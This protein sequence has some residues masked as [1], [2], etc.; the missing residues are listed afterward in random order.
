MA[1]LVATLMTARMTAL[2]VLVRRLPFAAT[3][4]TAT[5]TAT[6]TAATLF[7]VYG[8]SICLHGCAL[9]GEIIRRILLIVLRS[10]IGAGLVRRRMRVGVLRSIARIQLLR[11]TIPLTG[12]TTT[13]ASATATT[14]TAALP[15]ALAFGKV[16]T[17]AF[18]SY[19]ALVTFVM[20][21][22]VVY[23][24]VRMR[25]IACELIVLQ[26]GRR[27]RIF[28]AVI[29]EDDDAP[30]GFNAAD[31]NHA[32]R[33]GK[34]GGV[35]ILLLARSTLRL[36]SGLIAA[37]VVSA[38]PASTNPTTPATMTTFVAASTLTA[39]ATSTRT[40]T[41]AAATPP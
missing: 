9:S 41:T 15:F 30:F 1:L 28:I 21:I 20:P 12:T 27:R 8:N 4:P 22:G 26:R 17:L 35:S 37:I 40:A 24:I 3:T 18:V 11:S 38:A 34:P 31:I 5:A 6:T 36:V 23:P 32:R 39:L 25:C 2:I 13:A 14:A 16:R 29:T 19:L 33:S 7:T 10:R